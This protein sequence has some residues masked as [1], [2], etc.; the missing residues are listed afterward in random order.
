MIKKRILEGVVVS[1][2]MDKTITVEVVRRHLHKVYKKIVIR[3]KKFKAHDYSNQ[4]QEG[5]RVRIIESRPY[6]KDKRFRLLE[7]VEK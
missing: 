4:A 1:N 5:D 2:K 6:S 3:R 7:V